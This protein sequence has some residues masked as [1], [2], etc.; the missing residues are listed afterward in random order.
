MYLFVLNISKMVQSDNF[1]FYLGGNNQFQQQKQQQQQQQ[2]SQHNQSGRN[3]NNNNNQSRSNSTNSAN[4][5]SGSNRPKYQG[6]QNGHNDGGGRSHQNGAGSSGGGGGGGS[7]SRSARGESD[8]REGSSGK[9]QP[10]SNDKKFTGRC[11]LFVGNL[12]QDVSEREF[13]ELFAKYG[14][15]GEC[16][17]NSHKNF[18]FVKLDTRFNAEHAKQE[19]DGYSWK[20]IIIFSNYT[21]PTNIIRSIFSRIDI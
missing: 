13:K 20:G 15:I 16:F 19:L 12:P 3:Q 6:G 21:V 2:S 7:D 1:I 11:R 8:R 5:S 18:G 14:E 10:G 4:N 9:D 17:V